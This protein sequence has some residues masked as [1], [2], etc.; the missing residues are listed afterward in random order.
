MDE[1]LAAGLVRLCIPPSKLA[2]VG[3]RFRVSR[4]K[5]DRS[6]NVNQA[7]KKDG[8][9]YYLLPLRHPSDARLRR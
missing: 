4:R 5:L 9:T 2:S 7:A 6:G 1:R 8:E 3:L